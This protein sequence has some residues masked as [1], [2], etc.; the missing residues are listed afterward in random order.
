VAEHK[1][2]GPTFISLARVIKPQGNKGEV[3]VKLFTDFPEKFAERKRILALQKNGEHRELEIEDFWPHKGRMVLKFQGVDCINDAEMLAG[4]EL[5]VPPTERVQLE[6]GTYFVSD[7]VG[8]EV[9]V[10]SGNT[11]KSIGKI[12]EVEFNTGDAP[13]LTVMEGKR[14]HLIP[15]ASEFIVNIATDAKRIEMKLPDGLLEIDAPL[16]AVEKKQQHLP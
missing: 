11:S 12:T 8:C 5:Q 10:M 14:E 13:L 6:A 2:K 1:G 15:F 3:A 9:F 4:C 7:L 16:N